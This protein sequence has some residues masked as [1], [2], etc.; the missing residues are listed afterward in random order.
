MIWLWLAC[1]TVDTAVSS[2]D[3]T[4]DTVNLK[5]D[6]G[7]TH[8]PDIEQDLVEPSLTPA[9]VAQQLE[10]AFTDLPNPEETQ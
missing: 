6:T 1:S 8:L 4:E 5:Q 2:N 7:T 10:E 3:K 9:Q